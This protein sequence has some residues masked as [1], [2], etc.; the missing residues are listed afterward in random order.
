MIGRLASEN[1][2]GMLSIPTRLGT[3]PDGRAVRQ[4]YIRERLGINRALAANRRL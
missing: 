1:H 2:R 4:T 3:D